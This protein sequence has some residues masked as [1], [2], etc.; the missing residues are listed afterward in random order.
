MVQKRSSVKN[1]FSLVGYD[2]S[3]LAAIRHV[4]SVIS[5]VQQVAIYYEGKVKPLPF[6]HSILPLRLFFPKLRVH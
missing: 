5:V 4:K 3:C 6:L 2:D 1:L